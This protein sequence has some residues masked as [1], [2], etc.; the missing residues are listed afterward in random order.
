[1]HSFYLALKDRG[2]IEHV[3]QEE[4]DITS[5]KTPLDSKKSAEFVKNLKDKTES[6]QRAFEKQR[7][8]AAVCPILKHFLSPSKVK[9]IGRVGS[10]QVRRTSCKVDRLL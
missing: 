3:T 1:M 2:G 6:I 9:L 5:G 8:E 4:R 10:R 7:E